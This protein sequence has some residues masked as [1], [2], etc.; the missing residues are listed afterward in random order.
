MSFFFVPSTIYPKGD[1]FE[2]T[3]AL[4]CKLQYFVRNKQI[5]Q[6]YLIFFSQNLANLKNL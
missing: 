4:S 1:P 6:A 2:I 3:F 5:M